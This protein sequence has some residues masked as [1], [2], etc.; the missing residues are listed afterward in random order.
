MKRIIP[1]FLL[2]ILFIGIGILINPKPSKNPTQAT[3]LSSITP[4]SVSD[5]I[6]EAKISTASAMVTKVIDGDTIQVLL[7][8][9]TETIRLIGIDTPETVDPRKP[10][11]CF[12]KEASEEAEKILEG[13]RITL[14]S[15]PT[16]D[17]RDKYGRL[18]NYIF[19]ADG[20]NF[21][22]FMIRQGFAYEY[23]YKVPYKYQQEF[24]LVQ[25]E[26]KN[27]NLGLWSPSSCSGGV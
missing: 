22:L 14:E 1:L 25:K 19:L 21:N 26:A 12:E 5:Q 7:N 10:V 3:V 6:S 17:T 15:D 2:G 27:E 18:L 16:Q 11:Q 8:G 4:T 20:T 23:T 9:K 13:Q 24:K